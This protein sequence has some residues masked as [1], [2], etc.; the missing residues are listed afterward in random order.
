[1]LRDSVAAM[2]A[3]DPVDD[4]FEAARQDFL[5]SLKDQDIYNFSQFMSI[6]DVY[7]T[8]DK[9][10]EE[11]RRSGALRGLNRIRPYLDCLNQYVGVIDTFIQAKPDVLCLIWVCHSHHQRHWIFW[12]RS[13]FSSI[14]QAC[15]AKKTPERRLLGPAESNLRG[16]K[17]PCS[18]QSVINSKIKVDIFAGPN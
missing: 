2:S 7:D 3:Q 8:T 14:P 12:D 10:Q 17:L 9:I 18:S 6:N 1:M 13:K 15:V 4:A 11:Q 5:R 16:T